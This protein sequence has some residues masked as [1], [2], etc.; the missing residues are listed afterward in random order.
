VKVWE[1]V[2]LGTVQPD[3]TFFTFLIVVRPGSESGPREV[4]C[5]AAKTASSSTVSSRSA[6][7]VYQ[8]VQ[9]VQKLG[10]IKDS[11][12]RPEGR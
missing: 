3:M 10:S 9:P 8:G 4:A 2:G 1:A 5:V 6:A 11:G 12:A 7:V